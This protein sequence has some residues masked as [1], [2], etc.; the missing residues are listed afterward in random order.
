VASV[1]RFPGTPNPGGFGGYAQVPEGQN[2]V[3]GPLHCQFRSGKVCPHKPLE[4]P[5]KRRGALILYV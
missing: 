5:C 1:K 2:Y 4:L 3:Y